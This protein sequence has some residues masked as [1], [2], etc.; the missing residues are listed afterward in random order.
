MAD[1]ERGKN[2]INFFLEIMRNH[3][4]SAN[5]YSEEFFFNLSINI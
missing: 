4:E 1:V 2:E 5:F 3:S